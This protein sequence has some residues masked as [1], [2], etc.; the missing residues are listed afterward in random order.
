MRSFLIALV[1]CLAACASTAST[2]ST[3]T[4]TVNA[5]TVISTPPVVSAPQQVVQPAV[6]SLRAE[7]QEVPV[8]T[9]PTDPPTEGAGSLI[10]TEK[11][12]EVHRFVGRRFPNSQLWQLQ[13]ASRFVRAPKAL[14]RGKVKLLNFWEY[15]CKPCK[16]EMPLFRD[17]YLRYRESPLVSVLLITHYGEYVPELTRYTFRDLGMNDLL[18]I[19]YAYQYSTPLAQF[20]DYRDCYPITV[21]VDRD[22]MIR[23]V[24][25]GELDDEDK[26]LVIRLIDSL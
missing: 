19:V 22:N 14:A 1:L 25:E 7:E 5:P 26:A 4:P 17:L 10:A 13:D 12:P 8:A 9:K 2:K 3:T 16:E 18:P 6:S 11:P 23:W 21:V 24:K 15:S 20:A